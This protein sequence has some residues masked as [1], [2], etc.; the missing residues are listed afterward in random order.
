M[1]RTGRKRVHPYPYFA[2]VLRTLGPTVPDIAAA[3]GVSPRSVDSYLAGTALPHVR[4]VK[5]NPA[6]DAALT[7][8]FADKRPAAQSST[9]IS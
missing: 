4:V 9:S 5:L 3:L 8:D 6:I 2:E 7:L 1:A